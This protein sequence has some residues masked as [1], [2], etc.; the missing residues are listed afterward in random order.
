MYSNPSEAKLK[1]GIF[2]EPQIRK[3]LTS[4]EVEESMSD[5]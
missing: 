5:V 3:M 1:G 4:K 2:V